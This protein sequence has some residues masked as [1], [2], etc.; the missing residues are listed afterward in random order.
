[1]LQQT[2]L[3]TAMLLLRKEA[4]TL[5]R[6]EENYSSQQPAR[7]PEEGQGSPLHPQQRIQSVFRERILQPAPE[8]GRAPGPLLAALLLLVASLPGSSPAWSTGIQLQFLRPRR[9]GGPAR[10][11]TWSA[12]PAGGRR[13]P[14]QARE[15]VKQ[16]SA[17][18]PG[19]KRNGREFKCGSARSWASPRGGGEHSQ[20]SCTPRTSPRVS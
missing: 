1:M 11:R 5:E 12:T 15:K 9:D 20:A 3:L 6:K 16:N 18:T 2:A 4:A 19:E 8:Q 7:A 17:G 13:V 10:G 14:V